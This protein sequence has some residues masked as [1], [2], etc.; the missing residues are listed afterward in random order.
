MK[1]VSN[2]AIFLGKL[3]TEIS[4][5][6]FR[7]VPDS[8][9]CGCPAHRR[10]SSFGREEL[11]SRPEIQ[12]YLK[13]LNGEYEKHKDSECADA[14]ILNVIRQLR[15]YEDDFSSLKIFSVY[16]DKE[17]EKLIRVEEDE[18]RSKINELRSELL[19]F[20]N[21]QNPDDGRGVT[22]QVY[23][24]VGGQE[25][26]LFSEEVFD[27]YMKY[28]QFRNWDVDYRCKT[29]GEA[30]GIQ[31][32]EAIFSGKNLYKCLKHEAGVHRVQRVPVTEKSGKLQT[33]TCVLNVLP[34]ADETD[35]VISEKDLKV[36][37]KTSSGPGGQN[38]NKRET[39]VRITHIPTGK[40]VS[41]IITCT[42]TIRANS[43]T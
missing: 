30:G 2:L 24:G 29:C 12:N 21:P 31:K 17:L 15:K 18:L 33:S 9:L 16:N 32:A 13:F 42:F 4:K 43:S 11:W 28:A 14:P 22:I 36:E 26:K 19:A 38:V 7:S 27:M 41:H 5:R 37:V 3:R 6:H 23:P 25:A 34:N 20:A 35:I 40:H 1:R 10:F 8:D 39:C